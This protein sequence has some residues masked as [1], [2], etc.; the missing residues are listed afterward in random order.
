MSKNNFR[1]MIVLVAV[2]CAVSSFGFDL[3]ARAQKPENQND[4]ANSTSPKS[5]TKS[6]R[7][8][9]SR[10]RANAKATQETDLSGTYGGTFDCNDAGWPATQL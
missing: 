7:R 3:L 1:S 10:L 4:N 9:S 6:R 5:S 2:V 8:S